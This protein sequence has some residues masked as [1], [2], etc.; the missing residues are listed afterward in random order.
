MATPGRPGQDGGQDPRDR[1]AARSGN[2]AKRAQTP[3]PGS[4]RAE[5]ERRSV[6]GLLLLHRL[7]RWVVLVGVALLVAGGLFLGG[8]VGGILLLVLAGFLGWLVALSWPVLSA[9]ARLIRLVVVLAVAVVAVRM[10]LA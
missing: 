9:P 2:P 1:A 10:L 3:A 6:P 5:L 8:I 4:G 7:P